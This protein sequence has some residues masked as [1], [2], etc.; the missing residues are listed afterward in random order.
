MGQL[1]L[2]NGTGSSKIVNNFGSKG[3]IFLYNSTHSS[4]P[5][6]IDI[7]SEGTS[8]F[9]ALTTGAISSGVITQSGATLAN[10]YLSLSGG[11][12]TGNIA[13]GANNITSTTGYIAGHNYPVTANVQVAQQ[14][15]QGAGVMR[16]VNMVEVNDPQGVF[17]EGAAHH[18]DCPVTG[19]YQLDSCINV[20]NVNAGAAVENDIFMNGVQTCANYAHVVGAGDYSSRC[21]SCLVKC[22]AGWQIQVKSTSATDGDYYIGAGG[23]YSLSF[24]TAYLVSL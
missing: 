19:Y 4:G 17:T 12:M 8:T 21:V 11:T 14:M 20:Y 24:F 5:A 18:Y 6:E 16:V 9:G 15:N 22:T 3:Q 10:T 23:S 2:N 7:N 1:F 13:M